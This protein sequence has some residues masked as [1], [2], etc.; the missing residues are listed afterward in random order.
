VVIRDPSLERL[1]NSRPHNAD[2]A[3][4]RAAAEELLLAR[5]EALTDMRG[6]G[7]LVLDVPPGDAA[8]AVTEKYGRLKREGKL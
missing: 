1:A 5:A 2:G 6:R 7:V 3:F 4:S 8:K